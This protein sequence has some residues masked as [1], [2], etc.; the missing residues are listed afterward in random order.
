MYISTR[1]ATDPLQGLRRLNSMLDEAFAWPAR[2]EDGTLTANWTPACDIFEDK[3]SVRIVA[4]VPGVKPEDVKLSIENN[5]LTIRG[6]KQQQTEQKGERAHRFE[7]SYGVFER[8][9]ALPSTVDADRIEAT[10]ADGV[11]TVVIPKA[12]RAKPREIH[13]KVNREV[14]S[15]TA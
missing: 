11:L 8:T 13:V 4:E 15:Q 7:R 5:I 1:R 12:E 9:F 14:P 6:E 10:Y 2:R 3:D